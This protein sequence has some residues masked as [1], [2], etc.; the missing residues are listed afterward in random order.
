MDPNTGVIILAIVQGLCVLALIGAALVLMA[1]GR[2]A[3]AKMQPV[4]GPA[5]RLKDLGM[6]MAAT[7]RGKSQQIAA[8]AQAL[9]EHLAQKWRTTTRI[10]HEV[11][12]PEALPTAELTERIE[13]GRSFAERLARLRAAAQK[14]AGRNGSH[15]TP[16]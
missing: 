2:R 9:A 4:I 16:A 5:V 11:T 3:G 15:R 13:R 12:H 10:V 1:S 14:A 7:A 6:R 8:V